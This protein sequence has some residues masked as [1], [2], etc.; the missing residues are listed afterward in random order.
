MSRCKKFVIHRLHIGKIRL[1]SSQNVV[2]IAQLFASVP[3]R[4]L[5][6][7]PSAAL[8]ILDHEMVLPIKGEVIDRAANANESVGPKDLRSVASGNKL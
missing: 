5:T 1:Q 4:L 3:S 2:S 8:S 7:V 6:A